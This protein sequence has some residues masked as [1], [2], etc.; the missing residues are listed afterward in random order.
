[1]NNVI[2][3]KQIFST[4]GEGSEIFRNFRNALDK[5][6]RFIRGVGGA[7][8][9]YFQYTFRE[10]LPG[11]INTGCELYLTF[12][13]ATNTVESWDNNSNKIVYSQIITGSPD[14]VTDEVQE[15][16]NNEPHIQKTIQKGNKIKSGD[17]SDVER[18]DM[19]D[20]M[21]D[22][23]FAKVF[24]YTVYKKF[25]WEEF[26]KLISDLYK[27]YYGIKSSVSNVIK[28]TFVI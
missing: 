10:K 16:V 12:D 21:K 26:E 13:E 19:L 4:R 22:V 8:W 14:V 7:S 24:A 11:G 5:D 20:L 6:D 23:D 25:G 1:M 17:F 3:G 15:F 28:G 2:T 27:D 18:Y 9:S